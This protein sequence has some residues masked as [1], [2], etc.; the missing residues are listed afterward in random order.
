MANGQIRNALSN[1]PGDT[2]GN[3]RSIH[4]R[5]ISWNF[6]SG[7]GLTAADKALSL[8]IGVLFVQRFTKDSSL[9]LSLVHQRMWATSTWSAAYNYDF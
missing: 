2:G 7:S 3:Y 6:N 4:Y 8:G 1:E 9:N 5:K